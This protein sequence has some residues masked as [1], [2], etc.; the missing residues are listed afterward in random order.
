M[1]PLLLVDPGVTISIVREK[2]AADKDEKVPVVMCAHP[3]NNHLTP[4]LKKSLFQ[5]MSGEFDQSSSTFIIH[6]GAQAYA[7][8]N[9]PTIY[10][11]YSGIAEVTVTILIALFSAAFA[12]L[13]IYRMRRNNRID[14]FHSAV[15][16][17]RNS[18]HETSTPEV[19]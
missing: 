18:T 17:I 4:T 3:Y 16:A 8:R 14:K 10:E 11:R 12:G 6:P 13:R 15:V 19:R 5:E 7:Q 2:N 9:A 1:K